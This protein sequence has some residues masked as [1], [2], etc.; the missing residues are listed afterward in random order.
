[1]KRMMAELKGEKYENLTKEKEQLEAQFEAM[2]DT[3]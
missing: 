3:N 2:E 1:M